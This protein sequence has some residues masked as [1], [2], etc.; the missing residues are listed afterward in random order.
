VSSTVIEWRYRA[1]R[2]LGLQVRHDFLDF[3]V[4]NRTG[5]WTRVIRPPAHHVEHVTLAKELF[6][7]H[8]RRED[9][10]ARSI[11]EVTWKATRVGKLALIVPVITSTDRTLR[12]P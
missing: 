7:A 10:C 5:P 1:G 2:T 6:G 3:S 4:A 8:A 9:G 12:P 11:L